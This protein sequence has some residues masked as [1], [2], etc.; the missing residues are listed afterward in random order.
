[1]I[2]DR[3]PTSGGLS[4]DA[5]RRL[6]VIAVIRRVFAIRSGVGW[7]EDLPR[8]ATSILRSVPPPIRRRAPRVHMSDFF[9]AGAGLR[10]PPK[11]SALPIPQLALSAPKRSSWWTLVGPPGLVLPGVHARPALPL[12]QPPLP[13]C[14]RADGPQAGNRCT[15]SC[16]SVAAAR[17]RRCWIFRP[18]SPAPFCD[19][20]PALM[21]YGA[22]CSMRSRLERASS[23]RL[24][25]R[26]APGTSRTSSLDATG[27]T[28]TALEL[29]AAALD[30]RAEH[31]AEYRLAALRRSLDEHAVGFQAA[32]ERYV[33]LVG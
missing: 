15:G 10:L 19:S 12:R 1:V 7:R 26:S 2:S 29:I 5:S 17:L 22:S 20:L 24:A 14:K 8:F 13:V 11:G 23:T 30:V 4:L 3:A 31:F 27:P 9:P 32:C 6:P 33:E 28:M 18:T 25:P 21:R 16:E